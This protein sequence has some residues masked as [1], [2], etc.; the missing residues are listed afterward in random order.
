[1]AENPIVFTQLKPSIW[2]YKLATSLKNKGEK[3]V[4]ITLLNK[5]NEGMFDKEFDNIIS[6]G[7]PNLKPKTLFLYF[8]KNPLKFFSFSRDLLT[9]KPKAI[10]AE[11]APH[12]LAALFIWFFKSR[13]PRIYHPYDINSSR[14]KNPEKY[15]PKRE[16]WG[17]RYCFKNCDAI[18]YNSNIKEFE[19]LPEDFEIKNK[20][21]FP[22][23]HYALK[24]WFVTPLK[25]LSDKD[26]QIH[27]V[28][29]G[30]FMDDIPWY[31]PMSPDFINILKQKINLHLY[32]A[33]GILDKEQHEKLTQ[34]KKELDK[35]LHIHNYVNPDKLSNEIS[36]Y[37]F[38]IYLPRYS[39]ICLKE[40][41]ELATGN[42]FASYLEAGIPVICNKKNRETSSLAEENN[43]GIS[44][45]QTTNIKEKIKKI[46]KKALKT[47]IRKF[48]EKYSFEEKSSQIQAFINLLSS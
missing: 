41:D 31:K 33:Y 19:I 32:V 23:Q 27:L 30:S 26:K 40:A 39:S 10:I 22:V 45:Y 6:L 13:C 28:Y 34:G 3:I 37:D 12:Y 9:I 48:R 38:G 15:F 20:K 44:V 16:V 18:F 35:F 11:G 46:S 7:L 25:K 36:K 42:K 14:L 8:I 43:L 2:Q 4:L 29:T 21:K 24:K 5:Y 47:D 1:M 17:E